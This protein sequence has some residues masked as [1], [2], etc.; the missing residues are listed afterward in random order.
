MAKNNLLRF[1]RMELA[2]TRKCI[3]GAV[4]ICRRSMDERLLFPKHFDKRT[5]DDPMRAV[6]CSHSNTPVRETPGLAP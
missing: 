4:V 5:V 2:R 3:C 1:A 6:S